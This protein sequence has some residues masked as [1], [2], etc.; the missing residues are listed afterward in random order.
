MGRKPTV[1][2]AIGPYE[3]GPH[4]VVYNTLV[5]FSLITGT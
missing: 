5:M 2:E 4:G 3:P 1:G